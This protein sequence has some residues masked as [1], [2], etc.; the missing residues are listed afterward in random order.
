MALGLPA[1]EQQQL[2]D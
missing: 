2:K 1:K